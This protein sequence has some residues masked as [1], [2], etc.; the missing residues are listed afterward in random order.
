MVSCL[1]R[2]IVAIFSLVL[3]MTV[4]NSMIN[5]GGSRGVS[6]QTSLRLEHALFD[7]HAAPFFPVELFLM[8]DSSSSVTAIFISIDQ[9]LEN[10]FSLLERHQTEARTL[11]TFMN[12]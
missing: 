3:L 9:N 2:A 12:L 10:S 8:N 5:N 11:A 1:S 7:I 6:V 4:R